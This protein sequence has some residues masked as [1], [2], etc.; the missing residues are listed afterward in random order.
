MS[1]P[2]NEPSAVEAFEPLDPDPLRR[3]ELAVADMQAG[4]M[5]ILVDDEDRENEGDLVVA[6]EKIT[7]QIINFMAT[8]ARGLICLS[9]TSP[10]VQRLGLPMM[11]THNQSAYGTAFTVS[12]EARE[13]VT[14][15]ISAADRARTVQV[16]I[17][18]DASPR[19]IVTP[20]HMFPLCAK[21][22][23]VL[24]RV[25]QTE[26]S[27]D[28]SRMAGLGPAAVI[29]EIMRE[30]GSM[31]RMPDLLE[32]GKLHSIR[33]VTVADLIKH[34][35]RNER[36]VRRESSGS[37]QIPGLGEWKT[38]LYRGLRSGGL[39][40]AL[41][42]GQ[43]SREVTLVRV[44]AAPPPWAM[45]NP[46]NGQIAGPALM[47]LEAVHRAGQGAVVFMHLD[48]GS[49]DHLSRMFQ[50]DFLGEAQPA[51]QPRAEALRDLGTGCQILLDLGLRDLNLL[52]TS[53]RPIL[54]VEAYGLRILERRPLLRR[55]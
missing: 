2:V 42:Q 36:V 50:R 23:G 16:A 45:L 10:Q 27:V 22:G 19:D 46:T 35:M 30:D 44:Q 33:V 17:A 43:L 32:F 14:T 26:G 4:K 5:V 39:H 12:I 24:E 34:R 51:V 6:A 3:V 29:C 11:A 18:A 15:G 47:A 40:M 38:A 21:D 55:A 1:Q 37:V 8:Y 52:T 54:G 48:G 20:G 28:L 53:T 49:L 9:L 25:G 41:T 31:A 13:G 7:P